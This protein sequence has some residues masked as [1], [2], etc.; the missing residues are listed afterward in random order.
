MKEK[1]LQIGKR[2][3][4][5]GYLFLSMAM[6]R[7]PVIVNAGDDKDKAKATGATAVTNSLNSFYSIVSAFVS[8]TGAIILLWGVFEWGTSMQSNDGS[9]Q[10]NAFKRIGGGLVMILAP[11]II[12]GF[13]G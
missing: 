2:A 9:M 6:Q 10:A 7:A 8:A 12:A 4:M 5:A 13:I 1:I 3:A 11:Q